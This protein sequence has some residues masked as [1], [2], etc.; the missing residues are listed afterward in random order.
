M[1]LVPPC[2]L[3]VMTHGHQRDF[4]RQ[5]DSFDRRAGLPSE[6]GDA[7]AREVLRIAALRPADALLEIGAG[8]GQIGYALCGTAI[9][10]LGVDLSRRMLSEF[11]QRC[12]RDDRVPAMAVADVAPAKY[13]SGAR[14]RR[15]SRRTRTL[16]LR[17]PGS[18]ADG[19]KPIR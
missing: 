14:T 10:Y 15:P 16:S 4:D 7:V 17:S 12:R 19:W 3:P 9:R 8:T 1:Q 2:R 11:A 13:R 18:P 6:A 5:A